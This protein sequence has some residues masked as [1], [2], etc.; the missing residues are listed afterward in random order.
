M[1]K[2][3]YI[4]L[5]LIILMDLER[6]TFVQFGGA[7]YP[8][9]DKQFVA[10]ARHKIMS[11]STGMDRAKAMC[12]L[13]TG[14]VS[15]VH[16]EEKYGKRNSALFVAHSLRDGKI[17]EYSILDYDIS[18]AGPKLLI[19]IVD[20]IRTWLNVELFDERVARIGW[21]KEL[22]L[23]KLKYRGDIVRR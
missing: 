8:E 17:I 14:L 9:L 7:Y 22:E 16:F 13:A 5:P 15:R 11:S 2:L 10:S 19:E 4:P 3:S 23:D 20:D 12:D 18:K 21:F 1:I 6:K